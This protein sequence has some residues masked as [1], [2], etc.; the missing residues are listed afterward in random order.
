MVTIARATKSHMQIPKTPWPATVVLTCGKALGGRFFVASRSLKHEGTESLPELMNNDSRDYLPFRT[1]AGEQLF[2]NRS[3]IRT[4]EFECPDG[5]D[6]FTLPDSEFISPVTVVFRTES[7]DQT[8]EGCMS[9]EGLP[10]E[11][12][13]PID[14]LN[15][16][17]TF[18]LIFCGGQL[19]LVNH[20]AISHVCLH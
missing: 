11:Y 20:N 13:R 6:L 2:L 16:P 5:L 17:D 18:L 8:L 19:T 9:T 3:A 14:L 7:S 10:P 15:G 1:D 4:V 12:R